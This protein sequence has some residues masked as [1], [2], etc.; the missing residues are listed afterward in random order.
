M[1]VFLPE[2]R[3][4][5]KAES[6]TSSKCLQSLPKLGRLKWHI[7]GEEWAEN[8]IRESYTAYLWIWECPL[9]LGVSTTTNQGY[10]VSFPTFAGNPALMKSKFLHFYFFSS[11]QWRHKGGGITWH[12]PSPLQVEG[13]APTPP[14]PVRGKW[15]KM[16]PFLNFFDPT[17]A[18]F[19]LPQ[20]FFFWCR[21]CMEVLA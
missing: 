4:F 2:A 8:G 5:C 12:F 15:P 9:P 16:S 10:V 18:F 21:L 3:E 6:T 19:P 1:Q 13:S 20:Q 7:L 17:H 14:S 11:L